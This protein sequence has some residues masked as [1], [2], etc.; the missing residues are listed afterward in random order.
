M[1]VHAEFSLSLGDANKKKRFAYK[2]H[3][4]L[5]TCIYL[6]ATIM[7]LTIKGLVTAVSFA[8]LWPLVP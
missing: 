5:V 8:P 4:P 1:D 3:N 2:H 7:L 6:L